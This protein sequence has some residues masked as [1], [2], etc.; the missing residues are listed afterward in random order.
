MA[1]GVATF[2]CRKCKNEWQGGVG[3]MP[4]DPTVPSPPVNP[5][6]APRVDFYKNTKTG[7]IEEIRR[8]PDSTQSFRQGAPIPNPGEENDV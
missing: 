8:R 7:Q 5:K 6:D 2:K 3:T 4:Q 1:M